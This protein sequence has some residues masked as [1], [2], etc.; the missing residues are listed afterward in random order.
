MQRKFYGWG[1][2]SEVEMHIAQV[3]T[4][5]DGDQLWFDVRESETNNAK[6]R[7]GRPGIFA[8]DYAPAGHGKFL[9]H[10]FF[11]KAAAEDYSL[12]VVP[13]ECKGF[14]VLED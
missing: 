2:P 4:V 9:R 1:S 7:H 13:D 14:T 5:A 3:K 8:I 6:I 12:P 11:T 10:I